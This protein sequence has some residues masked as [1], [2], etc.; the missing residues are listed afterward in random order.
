MARLPGPGAIAAR[1]IV[2]ETPM[3]ALKIPDTDLIGKLARFRETHG[4]TDF[5]D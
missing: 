5:E 1:M 4:V 3:K 2:R